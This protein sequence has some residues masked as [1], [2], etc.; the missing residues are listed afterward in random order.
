VDRAFITRYPGDGLSVV[1]AFAE[2]K[3]RTKPDGRI[4]MLEIRPE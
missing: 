3:V 4:S 1:V 2:R